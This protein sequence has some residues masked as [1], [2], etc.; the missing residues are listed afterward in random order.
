[1]LKCFNVTYVKARRAV[2]EKCTVNQRS[3]F[4]IRN[5]F[6]LKATEIADQR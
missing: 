3:G 4:K 5:R 6:A 1:M 2:F